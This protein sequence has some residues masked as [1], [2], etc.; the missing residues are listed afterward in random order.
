MISSK[1]KRGMKRLGKLAC[2]LETVH[3]SK[4]NLT[5]W[6]KGKNPKEMSINPTE[7]GRCGTAA[8]AVGWLPKLFPR[9]W[10]WY[11]LPNSIFSRVQRLSKNTSGRWDNLEDAANYFS[12][13][14]FEAEHLFYPGSYRSGNVHPTTVAR[15]MLRLIANAE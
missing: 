5:L 12:I 2:F 4:F 9:S 10:K 14:P 7:E 6:V 11:D 15:R 13:T 1:R 3:P 8:C